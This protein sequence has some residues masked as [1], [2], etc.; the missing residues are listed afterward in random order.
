MRPSPNA[1]Q[2]YY[3]T[4]VTKDR[5]RCLTDERIVGAIVS[6]LEFYRHERGLRVHA[7]VVMP[8][9]IHLLASL[10]QREDMAG[11]IGHAKGWLTR[12]M[13]DLWAQDGDVAMLDRFR[14]PAE[15]AKRHMYRVWGPGTFAVDI[16]SP[17]MAARKIRYIHR[18]PV[19]AGLVSLPSE[20]P[21]SDYRWW[22]LGEEVLL[23]PDPIEALL[24]PVY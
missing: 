4:L 11:L 6:A 21:F 14:L 19:V 17:Q 18:P 7:S 9:H 16:Y 5:V 2:L 13:V 12:R 22:A 15:R 24:D 3:L 20:W 8:D 23:K 10:P 1:G